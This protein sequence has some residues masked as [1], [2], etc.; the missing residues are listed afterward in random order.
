MAEV[1]KLIPQGFA[2]DDSL[3]NIGWLS[4]KQ[5]NS[6]R[7]ISKQIIILVNNNVI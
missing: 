1:R 2:D 4:E 5:I 7:T 3:P 6:Y